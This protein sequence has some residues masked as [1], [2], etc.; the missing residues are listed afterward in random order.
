MNVVKLNTN[1]T[2]S[3]ENEMQSFREPWGTQKRQR[4]DEVENETAARVKRRRS[5]SDTEVCLREKNDLMQ[6]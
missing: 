1:Y 2:E 4:K 6:K 3:S 5:G